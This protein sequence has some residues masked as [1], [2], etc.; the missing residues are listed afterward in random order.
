[1]SRRPRGLLDGKVI[2]SSTL[3]AQTGREQG[4]TVH[5]THFRDNVFYKSNDPTNEV[6]ESWLVIQIA[7]N[8][9]RPYSPC[10]QKYNRQTNTRQLPCQWDDSVGLSMALTL[11]EQTLQ[12]SVDLLVPFSEVPNPVDNMHTQKNLV[13]QST[14]CKYRA[15]VSCMIHTMYHQQK[16]LQI[17]S[18]FPRILSHRK[19]DD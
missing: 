12:T 13:T 5:S 18:Y 7:L 16:L 15:T 6:K 3:P 14:L 8:L 10:L 17:S 2:K 1:M 4:L 11:I 9:T 19:Y